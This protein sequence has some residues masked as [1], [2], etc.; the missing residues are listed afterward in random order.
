MFLIQLIDKDEMFLS[1]DICG[2]AYRH[3]SVYL[4]TNV[5]TLTDICR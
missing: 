3:M 5:S 1:F 2:Y 4:L